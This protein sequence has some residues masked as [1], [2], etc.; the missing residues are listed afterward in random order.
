MCDRQHRRSKG[1]SLI[2]LSIT[3]II[4]SLLLVGFMKIYALEKNAERLATTKER[5]QELRTAINVYAATYGRLP[6]PASPSGKPGASDTPCIDGVPPPDVAVFTPQERKDDEGMAIWTGAVPAAEL[7]IPAVEATD[8]WHNKFTYAVTLKLTLP[9]A[10]MKSPAPPGAIGIANE[11][12][13]NAID[14]DGAGRYVVVSHG[15]TA[16]G[17]WTSEGVHIPC[18]RRARDG[19][20]CDGDNM[21]VVA[22]LSLGRGADFYDDFLAHDQLD[23][24]GNL[25]GKLAVCHARLRFYAPEDA[26][27]DGDGCVNLTA[28]AWQGICL[29]LYD[30][31]EGEEPKTNQRSVAT[32]SPAMLVDAS[33]MPT[34][35]DKGQCSC[36]AGYVAKEIGAWL[37]LQAG[38]E[39]IDNNCGIKTQAQDGSWATA[40]TGNMFTD[41]KGNPIVCVYK[42]GVAPTSKTALFTCVQ[43]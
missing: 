37:D 42:P 43:P 25:A 15:R 14:A 9:D 1:Y 18:D 33:N 26:R 38:T 36:P 39:T 34:V 13:E 32:L 23:T 5:L 2:E 35:S 41:E 31:G 4:G 24:G 10:L 20:N 30:S 21:F 17:A 28:N 3:L 29:N 12:G 6:C 40:N 19:T 7:G 16:Q 27:A 11:R 8:G 22:G